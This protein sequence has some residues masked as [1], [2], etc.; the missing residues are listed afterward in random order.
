M[1]NW[2]IVNADYTESS[3]ASVEISVTIDFPNVD[4]TLLRSFY[5]WAS[6]QS[7]SWA[8]G[9]IVLT[10][11]ESQTVFLYA[12]NVL[13]FLFDG[14]PYFGGDVFSYR[15]APLV[16]QLSPGVYCFEVRLIRD[17]RSMGGSGQPHFVFRIRT[18][19]NSNDLSVGSDEMLMPEVI[20]GF[21]LASSAASLPVLNACLDWLEIM[22]VKSTIVMSYT[23]FV[24]HRLTKASQLSKLSYLENCL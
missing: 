18:E 8:R 10:G 19:I 9:N 4:W 15:R 2:S 16:L 1:T 7:Q 17:V 20:D 23:A 11:D 6:V 5:G 12:D 14:V 21:G 13:E 24:R 3:S 22:A